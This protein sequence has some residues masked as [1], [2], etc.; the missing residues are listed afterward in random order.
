M[1]IPAVLTNRLHKK[2]IIGVVLILILTL[3][4]TLFAN[5]QLVERFYL[6]EQREYVRGIGEQLRIKLESGIPPQ[7]AVHEVEEQE[8]VFIVYSERTDSAE[9]T[10]N[11]LREKF[12]LKG[13]GFQKLW[14]WDQDY[15]ITLENGSQLRLYNQNKMNYSILVEYLSQG[16][17]LY[18]I[19]AIVPEAKEFINI[20]NYVGFFIYS[21]S[22]ILAILMIYILT[23][24]IT[25]PL[26]D[27]CV[28]TKKI[29]SHDYQPL[30]I[31][32]GDELEE[33]AN[34]LNEMSHD[35]EQYQKILEEKNEQMKSLLNNV[36]HD[37]K[38]PLS[39]VG[40]YA[41]GIKDGLDD[42]TFL[43][44]IICQNNKM[45]QIVEKLLH[46]SRIEY[47]E[48]PCEELALDQVLNRCIEEQRM[49]F[50]QR[51]LKLLEKVEHGIHINGNREL[52]SEL[53]SNLLSNAAK[54]ASSGCV[55]IELWQQDKKCFFLITNATENTALDT[56]LV[57]HPFYVGESSRNKELSGTGLGLSIVKKISEQFGYSVQCL[58]NENKISFKIGFPTSEEGKKE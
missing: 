19:A 54:Y 13:L 8:N 31:K 30:S 55:E 7:Q 9:G 3:A 53:F 51:D 5:S 52:L 41:A 49:L 2:F 28:F 40:M 36:A 27:V 10:A 11:A 34:S 1:R 23:R 22:I 48:Y 20:I 4:G 18:A 44:T 29:S 50:D 14:L 37:L 45:S 26:S 16:S 25:K 17:E 33:V 56:E 35:I 38:T 6:Y 43:D 58:M 57:W 39:L 12:R 46:L 32:T 47:K 42:G 15:E 21:F 24:H